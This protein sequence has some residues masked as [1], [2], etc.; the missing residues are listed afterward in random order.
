[1]HRAQL[2][3][4]DWHYQRLKARAEQENRSLS[5]LM[6]EILDQHL[7]SPGPAKGEGLRAIEGLGSDP[8]ISGRDHDRVLYGGSGH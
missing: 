1:M 3:L 8:E 4:E 2:L 5:N 7:Q 6:R